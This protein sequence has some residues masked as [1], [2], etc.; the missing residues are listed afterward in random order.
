MNFVCCFGCFGCT[1]LSCYQDKDPIQYYGAQDRQ[2]ASNNNLPTSP[3]RKINGSDY[4]KRTGPG[5]KIV[6][7]KRGEVMDLS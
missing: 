6:E 7:E 3:M 1:K 2:N 4:E 5:G